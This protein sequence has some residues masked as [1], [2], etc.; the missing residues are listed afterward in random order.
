MLASQQPVAERAAE[1]DE[2]PDC[3][4]KTSWLPQHRPLSFGHHLKQEG[5]ESQI[6]DKAVEFRARAAPARP[7]FRRCIP[8]R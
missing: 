5:G 4:G 7:A 8:P 6:D 2:A 3:K 1:H